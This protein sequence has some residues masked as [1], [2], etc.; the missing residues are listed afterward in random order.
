MLK[1][2][3]ESVR[4]GIED[5]T[6]VRVTTFTGTAEQVLG[7]TRKEDGSF[8]SMDEILTDFAPEGGTVQLACMSVLDIDGDALF[9]RADDVSDDL[10]T[11]HQEAVSAGIE[12]RAAII[13]LFQNVI[14]WGAD[15]VT[16][17]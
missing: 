5:L 15:Q 2:A 1:N 16:G 17:D 3:L 13:S 10:V 9:F 12:S 7:A 8:K 6:E 11:A 4:D 14:K